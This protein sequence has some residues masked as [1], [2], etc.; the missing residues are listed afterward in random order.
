[1]YCG[2]SI[3]GPVCR[4]P[5]GYAL[6]RPRTLPSNCFPLTLDM[7][8]E[9]EKQKKKS[10]KP[11]PGAAVVFVRFRV[12]TEKQ[13]SRDDTQVFPQKQMQAAT[14]KTLLLLLPLATHASGTTS[15]C[16]SYVNM[17]GGDLPGM[18]LTGIGSSGA[19]KAHCFADPNC[20]LYTFIGPQSPHAS[21]C[22]DGTTHGCC[23]LKSVQESGASPLVWDE[24]ACSEYK[25]VC[26]EKQLR[27]ASKHQ[28]LQALETC[29]I[30]SST[31]CGLIYSRMDRIS[32]TVLTL[33]SWQ[34]RV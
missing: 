16:V 15:D 33:P 24:N 3:C 19:C 34:V 17:P 1:M 10:S 31:T 14:M 20:S 26:Q 11:S 29:C 2:R 32:L 28:H 5:L 27:K 23:W 6:V 22:V 30:S 4:C 18:P 12:I 7:T 25:S 13:R 8:L 9:E 21:S